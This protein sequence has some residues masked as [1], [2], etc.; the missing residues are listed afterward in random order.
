MTFL[1]VAHS[2]IC[3][4]GS[5]ARYV[6]YST[7]YKTKKNSITQR[8]ISDDTFGRFTDACYTHTSTHTTLRV[9]V[10]YFTN[11]STHST[12]E[13]GIKKNRPFNYIHEKMIS[14][15]NSNKN[16]EVSHTCKF[17]DIYSKRIENQH[18][19][20]FPTFNEWFWRI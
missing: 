1:D 8:C 16:K 10:K 3:L 17:L 14:F 6:P 12:A 20:I 2:S 18:I 11:T 19:K 4:P 9:H 13:N 7:L 5:P 15:K